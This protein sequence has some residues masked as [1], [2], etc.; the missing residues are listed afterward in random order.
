MKFLTDEN[1]AKS[2]ISF[3]RSKK[4]DVCDLKEEGKYGLDDIEILKWVV[5]EKRVLLSH[6][7][8]FIDLFEWFERKATV[9]VVRLFR[10]TPEETKRVL[11][12]FLLTVKEEKIL[13]KLVILEENSLRI[14]KK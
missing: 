11:E 1:I 7:R 3:L 4:H 5:R 6:D 14:V 9:V 13:G 8:D 2:V 12:K 10:Q